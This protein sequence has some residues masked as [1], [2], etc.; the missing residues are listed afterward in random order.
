MLT[1]RNLCAESAILCHSI[2]TQYRQTDRQTECLLCFFIYPIYC[3][4]R[5]CVSSIIHMCAYAFIQVHHLLRSCLKTS[6]LLWRNNNR[7]EWGLYRSASKL[8]RRRWKQ[9]K[10]CAKKRVLPCSDKVANLE[11][12][13]RQVLQVQ[14]GGSA[15]QVIGWMGSTSR[16]FYT[17]NVLKVNYP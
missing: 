2:I 1:N 17:V 11:I 13:L 4:R 16:F 12:L 14:R 9:R 7:L 3:V 6:P 8:V 10:K 5:S 15:T